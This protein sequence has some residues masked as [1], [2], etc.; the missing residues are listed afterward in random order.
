MYRRGKFSLLQ[1]LLRLTVQVIDDHA[2]VSLQDCVAHLL[3]FS[4][5]F[6][7]MNYKR[8]STTTTVQKITESKAVQYIRERAVAVMKNDPIVVLYCTESSNDFDPKVSTKANRQSCWIKTVTILSC[9]TFDTVDKR[10]S[11]FPIAVGKKGHSHEAVELAFANEL[12]RLRSG[13]CCFYYKSS[14]CIVPV[15]LE[16]MVSLQDQL[17]R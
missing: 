17:E 7:T 15:Y 16:L 1:N 3:S 2:Y 5:N 11:T 8:V 12:D 6:S 10:S 14:S 13:K 9:N 4:H